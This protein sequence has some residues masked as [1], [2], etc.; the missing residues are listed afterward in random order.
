[1]TSTWR[2]TSA[3]TALA[4]AGLALISALGAGAKVS[5]SLSREAAEQGARPPKLLRLGYIDETESIGG[6]RYDLYANTR[7]ADSVS[8]T[9]RYGGRNA[10][11]QAHLSKELK[12]QEWDVK[13]NRAG[14]KVL[15][16]IRHSLADQGMAEVRVVARNEGGRVRSWARF[17]PRPTCS[18]TP[19]L[20]YHWTCVVS[21]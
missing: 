18:R 1:M 19:E 12:N 8:F 4:L 21:F 11:A 9:A 15:R 17:G 13:R 7:R 5:D 2:V 3:V 14:K 10:T 16:L 20:G 6:Y